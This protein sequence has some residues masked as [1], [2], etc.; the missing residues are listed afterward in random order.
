[1][2]LKV[3]MEHLAEMVADNV[4]NALLSKG[5]VNTQNLSCNAPEGS[6]INLTIHH[7]KSAYEKTETLLNHYNAFKRVLA[8]RDLEIDNLRKHGVPQESRSIVQYQGNRTVQTH[9]IRSVQETVDTAIRTVQ[10]SVQ[11]TVQMVAHIES[12][13]ALLKYDPYYK[14]LEMQ[15]FEGRTQED[16]ASYFKCSQVNIS[17]NK[18]RLI[19]ELSLIMFPDQ[20]IKEMVQ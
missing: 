12:S 10:D 2:E 11:T 5:L 1:M 13:M 4:V 8:N 18:K 7:G 16:I 19:E 6:T 20:A 9:G 17:K 15:Y 3:N 14:I